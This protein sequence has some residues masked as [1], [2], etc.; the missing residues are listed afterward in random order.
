MNIIE[1][2]T[3]EKQFMDWFNKVIELNFQKDVKVKSALVVWETEDKDGT[4]TANHARFNCD[5]DNFKW[6]NRAINEKIKEL[7]FDVFLRKHIN[8]YIE[9]IE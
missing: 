9:Y 1:F 2:K 8:D 4:C 3:R 5:L 7:E 6:F